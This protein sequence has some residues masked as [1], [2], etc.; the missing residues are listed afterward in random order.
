MMYLR[1]SEELQ[2]FEWLHE[3]E[4]IYSKDTANK[5]T[6]ERK[7]PTEPNYD[8]DNFT[9][10][11]ELPNAV[12]AWKFVSNRKSLYDTDP[13]KLMST[14]TLKNFESDVAAIKAGPGDPMYAGE[15]A[16]KAGDLDLLNLLHKK[17]GDIVLGKVS[18][19]ISADICRELLDRK[20]TLMDRVAISELIPTDANESFIRSIKRDMSSDRGGSAYANRVK[21]YAKHGKV[22]LISD[23]DNERFDTYEKS[24][25][26]YKV[27]TLLEHPDKAINNIDLNRILGVPKTGIAPLTS[28]LK[29]KRM[30][31]IEY[32]MEGGSFEKTRRMLG[33]LTPKQKDLFEKYIVIKEDASL[34]RDRNIEVVCGKIPPKDLSK[35]LKLMPKFANEAGWFHTKR[36]AN[37]L[38]VD[39]RD[40]VSDNKKIT[41]MFNCLRR[42]DH[43]FTNCLPKERTNSKYV[44]LA[45]HY[46]NPASAMTDH[47]SNIVAVSVQKWGTYENRFLEG[48]FDEKKLKH[49]ANLNR[50]L[51][52]AN[53]T[54]DISKLTFSDAKDAATQLKCPKSTIRYFDQLQRQTDVLSRNI[55]PVHPFCDCYWKE[56]GSKKLIEQE[57][58]RLHDLSKSKNVDDRLEATKRIDQSGL[59]KMTKDE[60][61]SVR[62]KVAERI[63]QKG[64][65]EMMSD[66]NLSVR[67]KVAKRIDQ[68]AARSAIVVSSVSPER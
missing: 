27:D 35:I 68:K 28:G 21:Y 61:L 49:W 23:F 53:K 43:V 2:F 52:G 8:S 36:C 38:H 20:A 29:T 5:F 24:V 57:Q 34:A 11:V 7:I 44:N 13:D 56:A 50:K 39:A 3:N 17:Y 63:D 66:E 10:D 4:Q 32:E 67:S 59:R 1:E 48:T 58:V 33:N 30:C 60:S 15:N 26:N 31:S 41:E 9:R 22:N 16:Q 6:S 14:K 51:T 18:K 25:K 62:S 65:H 55:I 42:N 12:Q 19:P 37:H 54:R 45:Q 46:S 64:L 40:V 47:F